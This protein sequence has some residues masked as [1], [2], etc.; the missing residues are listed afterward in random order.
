MEYEIS[1]GALT[2]RVSDVGAQLVSLRY[3]NTEY[4]W[5]GGSEWPRR[6]P[7]CCPYC[8]AVEGESFT[9]GGRSYAAGRHG[10]VRDAEHELAERGG[11]SLAFAFA[12]GEGDP[13]WPWPFALRAEYRLGAETLALRYDIMNSGAQAMP[14]Q[15]GFHPGFIAPAGSV[16]RAQR[17][18]FPGGADTLS[19]APGLFD[20][21]ASIDLAAPGSDWFRLERSDGRAVTVDARGFGWFL[22]WGVPGTTPFV[23]LEPWSGYPGPGGMFD[24]PG[25]TVLAPGERFTRTLNLRLD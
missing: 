1:S 23:C 14:L 9:H 20:S 6:A 8:G 4:L 24:R 10:F 7:I 15:L 22:L 17:P 19:L 5:Q 25:V 12:L 11:D 2:A 18:D 21:G 3:E 16:V 13:R